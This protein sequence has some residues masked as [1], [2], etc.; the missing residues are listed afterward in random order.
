M[1]NTIYQ[2]VYQKI[3][4]KHD[5][6]QFVSVCDLHDA[7]LILIYLNKHETWCSFI[8]N[9]FKQSSGV[10]RAEMLWSAPGGTW[11]RYAT[12]RSSSVYYAPGNK[13]TVPIYKV[14]VRPDLESKSRPISTKT[15]ALTSK[16]RAG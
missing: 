12:A 13:A 1:K 14:L 5:L 11:S 3:Y 8:L 4:Q 6:F 2:N 9:S 15:D 16:P 7:L 10:K